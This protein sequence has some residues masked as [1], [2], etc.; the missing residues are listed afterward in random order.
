MTNLDSKTNWIVIALRIDFDDHKLFEKTTNEFL[1]FREYFSDISGSPKYWVWKSLSNVPKLKF[2]QV[3]E[4]FEAFWKCQ[5]DSN[6]FK[7]I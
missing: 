6:L 4:V 3:E 5:I 2:W 7:S 1:V